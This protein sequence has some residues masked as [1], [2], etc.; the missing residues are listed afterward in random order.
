[1]PFTSVFLVTL[2]CTDGTMNTCEREVAGPFE[3]EQCATLADD[4]V[5]RA[6]IFRLN[7]TVIT[8]CTED[9][10]DTMGVPYHESW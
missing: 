9:R 4:V 8:Y 5:M 3:P 6:R 7:E 10:T 2:L 1:M